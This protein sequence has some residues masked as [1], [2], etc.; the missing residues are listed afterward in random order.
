MSQSPEIFSNW[1]YSLYICVWVTCTSCVYSIYWLTVLYGKCECLVNIQLMLSII[2][3]FTWRHLLIRR[4]NTDR[5]CTCLYWPHDGTIEQTCTFGRFGLDEIQY[6]TCHM[7]S[8]A[9]HQL[10]L[11]WLIKRHSFDDKHLLR[12]RHSVTSL[13]VMR[14]TFCLMYFG[15][16]MNRH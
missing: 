15:R 14:T 12:C 3:K 6:Y 7:L 16:K 4:V 10:F 1:D 2:S 8:W 11:S 13:D 9:C 5:G